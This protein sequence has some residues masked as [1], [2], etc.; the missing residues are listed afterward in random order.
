MANTF[1]NSFTVAVG[2]SLTTAYTTPAATTSTIIGLSVS[3]R[4]PS[5][6]IN[7]DVTATDV[8]GTKTVYLIKNAPIPVGGS[9]VIVGGEQKVVLETT[10]YIQV[11][12]T[13]ASSADVIISILELS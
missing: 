13:V 9:L 1:K 8:S 11:I 12:S 2:T 6:Q 7:V 5:T 3:N 10:D 4:L